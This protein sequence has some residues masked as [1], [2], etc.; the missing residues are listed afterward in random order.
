MACEERNVDAERASGVW[1]RAAEHPEAL[2]RQWELARCAVQWERLFQFGWEA[3]LLG[4][5][6][7][8]RSGSFLALNDA[9]VEQSDK[10]DDKALGEKREKRFTARPSSWRCSSAKTRPRSFP[11]PC[12]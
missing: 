12:T 5:T 10:D 9:D 11:G 2:S 3:V 7:A 8:L 6:L 1:E 4:I